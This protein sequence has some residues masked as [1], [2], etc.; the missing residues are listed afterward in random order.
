MLDRQKTRLSLRSSGNLKRKLQSDKEPE[1]DVDGRLIIRE[2]G[3]ILKRTTTEADL[4][5]RSQAGSNRQQD[6]R[7]CEIPLRYERIRRFEYYHGTDNTKIT[8]KRLK[9]DKHGHENG[10]SAKEP[11][12][13]RCDSL[14]KKAHRHGSS[15][16]VPSNDLAKQN[17]TKAPYWSKCTKNDTHIWKEA[18]QEVE[19]YTELLEK[20]AQRGLAHGMPRWQSVCSLNDPTVMNKDPMIGND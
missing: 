18:H 8:R 11:A 16:Q 15:I 14:L 4:D 19:F 9:P 10:K 6:H 17:V 13:N 7:R 1:L 20:E 3:T 2:D 12:H 5:A